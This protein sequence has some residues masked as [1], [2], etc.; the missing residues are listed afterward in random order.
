MGVNAAYN[1]NEHNCAIG[2]IPEA[3]VRSV[4]ETLGPLFLSKM[5]QRAFLQPVACSQED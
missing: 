2:L 5:I 1:W 4:V 3:C